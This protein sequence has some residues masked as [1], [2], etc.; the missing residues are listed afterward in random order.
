M[1]YLAYYT[2]GFQESYIPVLELSIKSL[3]KFNPDI[4]IRV[5]CDIQFKDKIVSILPDVHICERPNSSTAMI[6]SIHKLSVFHEDVS[7]YDAIIFIDSDILVGMPLDSLLSRIENENQL[8]AFAEGEN[9]SAHTHIFWSLQNYSNDDLAFFKEHNIRVFNAGLFAFK[10]S[11]SMKSHFTA[12]ETMIH[13]YT[14]PFFY[15]QSFMNVYFNKRN[16]I[17][18]SVFTSNNYS[19]HASNKSPPSMILHFCGGPGDGQS[20]LCRMNSYIQHTNFFERE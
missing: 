8:Y 20:K 6:A 15:E 1:K 18:Y 7:E 2:I 17:N 14:G 5:L 4:D 19:M 9:Q 11:E 3:R 12:I 16:L 13:E 10:P